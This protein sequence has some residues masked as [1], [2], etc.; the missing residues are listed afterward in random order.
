MCWVPFLSA[1]IEYVWVVYTDPPSAAN[2]CW[3]RGL[4][5][6][7]KLTIL[8]RHC[9]R[10][11]CG[12]V[13]SP[14]YHSVTSG[15]LLQKKITA[16][17]LCY[18]YYIMRTEP[19]FQAHCAFFSTSLVECRHPWPILGNDRLCIWLS[20]VNTPIHITLLLMNSPEY[21]E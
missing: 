16:L 11:A 3:Y 13:T 4:R 19:E 5:N 21:H 18:P 12:C 14:D 9:F 15:R 17:L 8:P 1:H 6:S 10:K 20:W 2:S 7:L